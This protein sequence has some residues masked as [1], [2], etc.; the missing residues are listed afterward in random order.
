M[1][2]VLHE[3]TTAVLTALREGTG[4]SIGD[5]EAPANPTSPYAV[6]YRIT[7]VRDGDLS[8]DNDAALIYQVSCYAPDRIGA[9]WMSGQCDRAL[10]RE[11]LVIP[12]RKVMRVEF[13]GDGPLPRE[14]DTGTSLFGEYVRVRIWTTPA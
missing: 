4:K 9:E 6:L 13:L 14:E 3:H 10:S 12:A 5:G 7:G 1:S 2:V 8:A 11:S